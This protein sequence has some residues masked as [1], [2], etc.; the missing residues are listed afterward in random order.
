MLFLLTLYSLFSLIVAWLQLN[1]ILMTGM[2]FSPLILVNS[3]S[4]YYLS[5]VILCGMYDG[6]RIAY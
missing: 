6:L 2:R 1:N 3:W 4:K 5:L